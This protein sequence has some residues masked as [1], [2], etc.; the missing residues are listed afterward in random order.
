MGITEKEG[1]EDGNV[2]GVVEAM[3][4]GLAATLPDVIKEVE[5]VKEGI[6][7][8]EPVNMVEEDTDSLGDTETV[9]ELEMVGVLQ[10][11]GF[12]DIPVVPQAAGQ[13]QG[14][15]APDPEGQ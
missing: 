14:M 2:E 12:T 10:A 4:V 3:E 9:T 15:G 1:V 13:V 7:G 8:F 11:E 5:G 6:G